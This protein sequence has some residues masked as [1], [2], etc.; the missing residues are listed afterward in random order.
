MVK[1]I[2][3]RILRRLGLYKWFKEETFAYDVYSY[4][5]ERRPLGWR[6]RELRF[7]RRLVGQNEGP[8]L[9]FDVGANC[10][11]KTDVFLKLGAHV[12]AVEPDEANLRILSRKYRGALGNRPV[13][14]VAMAVSDSIRTEKLW[15][16]APG[17]G[18]NTLSEKW[19]RTLKGNVAK[20]GKSVDFPCQR[21]VPTTT[22]ASLIESH[23]VPDYIKIDVEGHEPQ[24]LRGLNAPVKAVSFEAN[25]PE[26]GP[27]AAE[28][29]GIL[30]R[31][32]PSGRFNLT[33]CDTYQGFSLDQWRSGPEIIA[34]LSTLGE[35]TVEIYWKG[36]CQPGMND[37]VP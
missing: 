11:K 19:V 3:Q 35:R 22:L 30:S 26:F 29:I 21:D 18:L 14:I 12:V 4:F 24:V 5:K 17:D 36:E 15:V 8:L 20:F 10:G 7:F 28:C 32:S 27:E 31:L 2:L 6:R 13:T 1:S 33:S 9:I 34:I 37:A 23:G 25:L 16:T